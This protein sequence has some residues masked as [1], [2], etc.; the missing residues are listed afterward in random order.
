MSKT[1]IYRD[2]RAGA[3]WKIRLPGFVKERFDNIEKEV[4]KLLVAGKIVGFFTGGSEFGP[5]ALGHRSILADPRDPNMQ[6]I[7]NEKVK[8]RQ[9]F[10]PFAPAVLEEHTGDYFK[11]DAPSPY[12]LLV[13]D[14]L[15]DKLDAIP[16]ITH[17][18]GTARVQTVPPG[19]NPFRTVLE[20]FYELTGMPVIL[21]TSFNDHGHPIVETPL[22]ALACFTS[23]MMDVLA[24][25]P[26]LIR[27]EQEYE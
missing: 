16:A 6:D 15:P 27:K 26:F 23:T 22:D 17:V 2:D 20:A 24:L 10:R 5:R 14:V 25:G 12:M 19:D 1:F 13:A 11:L 8:H 7:I 3:R 21:N 9:W 4:A 18:D